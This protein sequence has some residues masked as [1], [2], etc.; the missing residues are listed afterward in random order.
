MNPKLSQSTIQWILAMAAQ[1][2][3]GFF[4]PG[5]HSRGS[6]PSPQAKAKRLARNKR[7]R[8]ARKAHQRR[9]RA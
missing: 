7:Q 8:Q 3:S 9:L 2:G 6:L 4:E 5:N 1:P